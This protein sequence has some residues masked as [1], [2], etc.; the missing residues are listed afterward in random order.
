ME[1]SASAAPSLVRVEKRDHVAFVT[2]DRPAAANALSKGLVADLERAFVG[3]AADAK[4]GDVHAVVLTGAGERAF[5]AGADLKERRAMSL[6]ETWAFLDE[7]NRLIN[8][9]AAFPRPVI[10]AINGAAFGGGLELALAADLRIAADG[11]ELGL[12]EVR[13]G[14]IPGA[15][16][17]QRLARLLGIAAAKELILTGRRIGAARALALGLV[18]AVVPAAELADAAARL[19]A[20]IAGAGPLATG[21]AK[22]AIDG[23]IELPL[24]DG[25]ALEAACYEEVLASDD[26]NEALAAFA[27]KRPPVFK[28]R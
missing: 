23:G 21:A 19:G 2:L 18:S 5:C 11:A 14:I 8:A 1:T 12:T 7:L 25:L 13:L 9:V 20:E 28:G 6:D 27:E 24:A 10:A 16:G 17:T 22:R 3:L 15:G 26:R 4:H